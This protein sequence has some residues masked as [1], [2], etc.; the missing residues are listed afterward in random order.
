MRSKQAA[1]VAIIALAALI[2]IAQAPT[3]RAQGT[4]KVLHPFTWAKYPSG[5][6]T[7][8]AQGNLYGAT[9]GGG[10]ATPSECKN[11]QG[12][13]VIFKL[14]PTADGKWDVS[15]LHEFS[16]P[17]GYNPNGG[18]VFDK[19]GNLY[20]TTVHGGSTPP[21][22]VVF[23]LSL[24]S[25]KSWRYQVIHNFPIPGDDEGCNPNPG[26]TFDSEGNLFGITA[27]GGNQ[28]CDDGGFI[29]PGVVFELS[30]NADGSWSE[31]VPYDCVATGYAGP[32]FDAVGNLYGTD[33]AGGISNCEGGNIGCGRIFKLTPGPNGTWSFTDIYDF[34]PTENNPGGAPYTS[35]IL[36]RDGDLYGAAGGIFEL[37]PKPD[38]TWTELNLYTFTGN[39]DGCCSSGLIFDAKGN[40]YGAAEYGGS[41]ACSNGCGLVFKL[42]PGPSE[43][44]ETVLHE[45]TG[46]GSNPGVIIGTIGTG[47][48][49]FDSAGNLYGTTPFGNPDYGLVFEITP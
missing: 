46:Y 11:T 35:L 36:D 6:L 28:S 42:T 7:R 5:T 4:F 23:K 1:I 41:T 43:W 21:C 24:E 47:S 10:D 48:L 17:D 30:P 49:I 25:N 34:V 29:D 26:L 33:T 13:G 44:T 9:T 31:S 45:F 2:A 40:L 37:K 39:A 20:G 16:G 12:C 3:A 32:V 18:L 38:G 15:I 22:G 14:A 19:A 8:D 27:F